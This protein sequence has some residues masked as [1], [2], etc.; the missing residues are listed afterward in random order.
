[1]PWRNPG[2]I[3]ALARSQEDFIAL[4]PLSIVGLGSASVL[5]GLGGLQ[6]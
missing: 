2:H 5:T 6:C 3:W 4:Q 1:M